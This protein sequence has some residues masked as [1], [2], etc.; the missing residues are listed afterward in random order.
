ML[1]IHHLNRSRSARVVWLAEELGLP[2]RIVAHRRD[3]RTFLAP[4]S[5]RALHPLGHAP[6]IETADGRMLGE[7]GAI[8]EHLIDAGGGR[9][10]PEGP[11]V[12]LDRWRF[13]MHH[14]EGSA[15]PPMV[16]ALVF[17][18]IP[19]R[20]PWVLRP[21]ARKIEAGARKGYFGREITRLA[22]FWDTELAATGWFAGDFSAADVMMSFPVEVWAE[23][24]AAAGEHARLRDWLARVQAR[25]AYQAAQARIAK[26]EGTA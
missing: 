26:A 11:G 3:A 12:A 9:L 16:M 8:A 5:L 21:L 22:A 13:W 24:H 4:E 10:R 17:S 1:T 23:R 19:A 7:T 25:S 15:M 20:A 18:A 14:A 2:A 6:L